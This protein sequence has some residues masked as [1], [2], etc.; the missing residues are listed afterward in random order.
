[1]RITPP[2]SGYEFIQYL[3]VLDTLRRGTESRK[4]TSVFRCQG[5]QMTVQIEFKRTLQ[6]CAATEIGHSAPYPWLA[7]ETAE[8]IPAVAVLPHI[9]IEVH[10]KI[11][12]HHLVI[13]SSGEQGLDTM[14]VPNLTLVAEHP[15]LHHPDGIRIGRSQGIIDGPAVMLKLVMSF[16]TPLFSE[17]NVKFVETVYQVIPSFTEF[18]FPL[19]DELRAYDTEQ[20][21]NRRKHVAFMTRP[22]RGHH[23]RLRIM[24]LHSLRHK[25]GKALIHRGHAKRKHPVV[26]P[27]LELY[28]TFMPIRRHAAVNLGH[29]SHTHPW[30]M[31]RPCEIFIYFLTGESEL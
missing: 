3:I 18:L 28:L 13:G 14:P 31:S 20:G 22:T 1:M 30:Q 4:A 11:Y 16:L 17:W 19:P 15:A 2:G 5:L 6:S 21:I 27:V 7:E 12:Y 25:A 29:I 24:V 26:Y 8:V 10:G 9:V 23:F